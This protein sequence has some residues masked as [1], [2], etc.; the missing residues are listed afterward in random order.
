MNV[1]IKIDL[2]EGKIDVVYRTFFVG[3]FSILSDEEKIITD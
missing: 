1:I 3:F 2:S